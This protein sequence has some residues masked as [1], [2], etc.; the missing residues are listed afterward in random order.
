VAGHVYE[1]EIEVVEALPF[2]KRHHAET[3]ISRQLI[4]TPL[5]HDSVPSP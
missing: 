3:R 4:L 5:C 1:E 2:P